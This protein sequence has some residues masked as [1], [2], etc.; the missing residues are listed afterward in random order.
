[1]L[2]IEEAGCEFALGHL[3]RTRELCDAILGCPGGLTEKALAANLLVEVYIRQSDSRLALE[4]ALCWLGIFGI[5]IGR[6]PEDADCDEAWRFCNRTGDAPQSRFAQ[7]SRMDNPETEAVMNLLYSASICASF[8]CPR[9]HFLLLCRMM[10][11]TLDHGI[12]GAS[13]TA[14]AW[15][16]VLIG[17]RYAEYRLGF[18][19]GTLARELVNRHGYDAFEAK[20]LLPLD[21][22]SVWTQPLSFTIECAK[23]C[24]TAAVTHGD[25]TMACFAACH[26]VINFLSRGDHLDGVL[27]S[28]DRGLAFVRKTHFQDVETI[29]MVQR[30]YVE[31]L[32]TPVIGTWTA[33]QVL[34]EALLPA[35]PGA[36]ADSTMLFWYWLYRGMA[37]FTC[38]E[39]A[40]A[41]ADLEMAGWYAWSAPGHIHLLDYHLYSAGAFRQ[42]TPE[43]FSANH[44]RSIHAHYDKIALWARINPGTFADKEALIYAEIVRLDGMNS[45]ALEQYEKAVRLSREGGFNPIN[46]LAHELAGALR[47][48]A[49][50]RP[51]QTRISAARLPPGAVPGRRPRC[52]SWSRISRTCWPPGRPAPMTRWRSPRMRPSAI[53]RA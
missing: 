6:Y 46:A 30:G 19:Y 29:L 40:D 49:A 7:L 14:M 9:L 22:L 43:T 36:G 31:F 42:L 25:M 16:G 23:A 5:Q 13:T 47:W 53:C 50:T 41:Q 11:L 17:H 44:R 37:H 34:P 45:I 51:P 27:T 38:G 32:R 8:I 33:S 10:H 4:A 21:Q 26:Q 39:Y 12:T 2:D 48:P 3:E 18:Q 15:F 1:M 24:F 20:T 28:I 35:S 52:A